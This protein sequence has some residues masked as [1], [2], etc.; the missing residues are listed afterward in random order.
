MSNFKLTFWLGCENI[1]KLLKIKKKQNQL[2]HVIE[3]FNFQR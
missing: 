1:F 3:V 2:F